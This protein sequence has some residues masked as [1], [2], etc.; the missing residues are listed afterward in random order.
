MT[1]KGK[2]LKLSI[3]SLSFGAEGIGRS[4]GKVIF[5]KNALPGDL[6][7]AEITVDKKNYSL[8]R[9]HRLITPSKDR[10]DTPCPVFG[11][12][13]GCNLQ[14]L[15][16]TRQLFEKESAVR[17]T[18]QRIGKITNLNLQPAEAS[19]PDYGYRSKIV[20]S[21][22][23]SE[24]GYSVSFFEE[25]SDNKIPVA[26]CPVAN[27]IVNR[28]I[29]IVNEFLGREVKRARSIDRIFIASGNTGMG[30]TISQRINRK[31]VNRKLDPGTM[32]LTGNS[33]TEI[34]SIIDD[35]HLIS[36]P[37][38]FMQANSYINLKM[39]E[40][41]KNW[42]DQGRNENVLDLYC[43]TG[44]FTLPVS[45]IAGHVTGV[46]KDGLAV[47]YARRNSVI[48]KKTNTS[49]IQGRA[50][51]FIKKCKDNFDL[52]ILDPPREGARNIVSSLEHLR[53]EKI[54][55]ISCNPATL[56]R[57]LGELTNNGYILKKVKPF[58][59]FPHTYHI[60]VMALLTS[61]G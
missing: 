20:L 39:I 34:E 9:V 19:I 52:V 42:M 22:L 24:K 45:K 4:E 18:L 53:P 49:F 21:T 25:G 8:A 38:V 6:V 27:D 59:M 37:S 32:K 15:E 48:N 41:I 31:K 47:K 3:E 60:E 51:D 29:E 36:V 26:H 1:Q 35:L 61:P 40:T 11:E 44:N 46:E 28:G 13:G 17:D 2:I 12:C 58:D 54:I 16:Y 56:A 57:D 14:D 33:E 7:E 55:Y 43:G 10:V 50:D 30:I 23:K 5:V